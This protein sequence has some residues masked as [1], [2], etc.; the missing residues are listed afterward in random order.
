MGQVYL[1]QLLTRRWLGP[2]AVVVQDLI[3]AL[4]ERQAPGEQPLVRL[5][6]L[7]QLRQQRTPA[8]A[9]EALMVV[10]PAMAAPVS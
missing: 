8:Q 6:L 3:P 7:T 2:E 1:I 5:A 9:R 4:V 10:L